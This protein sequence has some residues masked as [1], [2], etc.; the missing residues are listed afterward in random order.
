VKQGEGE[1]QR[2]ATKAPLG[3]T[4]ADFKRDGVSAMPLTFWQFGFVVLAVIKVSAT[5]AG[6]TTRRLTRRGWPLVTLLSI[7]C[8]FQIPVARKQCHI[9]ADVGMSFFV[10]GMRKMDLMNNFRAS[11]FLYAFCMQ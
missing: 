10:V 6:I 11:G 1:F 5:D 9:A 3:A 4:V 2:N 7:V 8:N